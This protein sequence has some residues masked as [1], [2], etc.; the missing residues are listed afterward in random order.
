MKR[1]AAF[2]FVVAFPVVLFAASAQRYIVTTTHPFRAAVRSLPTDDF[3]PAVRTELRIREFTVINGF[4]ADLTDAQATR[5]LQSGEVEN[6]EP[7]LE[8]HVLADS[9][10]PGQQTT[11]YGV[12]M[13]N[14]PS[15]WPVTKGAAINGTGPTH[16]AI[17]DTGIDYHS[18]EL[19]RAYKGGHNF[20]DNNDDPLDDFGHGTHVSGIIGAADDRVGVVGVAPDA[21][22]YAL[23]V[24]D[25]C[26]SGSTENVIAAI[27]WIMQKKQAIGGNWVANLSLGSS[28]SSTVEQT[29]FQRGTD[30]G[31]IFFAA[32]GNSYDTNPVDGLSFPAGYPSVISVGAVDS[33]QTVAT[34]SQRGPGLKVVAPGVSVLSTIV[35]ASVSTSDGGSY[36]GTTPL[37]VKNDN[38]DPLANYCLPSPK[39]SGNFVFC[40]FGGSASE[41]PASVQGKVALISRGPAGAN[42]VKFVDKAKNAMTAGAIGVIVYNNVDPTGPFA[43]AFGNFATA[44]LVPSFLPFVFIEQAD[45]LAIKNSPNATVTLGF[46]YEGWALESGTSMSTP[47]ATAVAA[48]VWAAAPNA[49]ATDVANAVINTAKDLGD[50]GVDN[51]YGHGLVNALDAAKLLNPGAFGGTPTPTPKTGRPPGRRG[52]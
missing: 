14:A 19:Q 39:V 51:V 6:I 15:V 45:G 1:L 24:L 27:D 23:K 47:H 43:P 22:I 18:S 4:A 28:D 41:F 30:A 11:P 44:S 25:Q 46:G 21:D 31:I 2:A 26:G 33:T 7:V 42:G 35:S 3:D 48:L 12:T 29:A 17:I 52:H 9:V 5:L 8:R 32:S 50:V 40:G 16:V 37:I 36:F 20:I 38:L 34:F 10:T 13:V 49:S